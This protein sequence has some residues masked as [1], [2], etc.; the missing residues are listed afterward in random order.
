[1]VR[2]GLALDDA[3]AVAL[4]DTLTLGVTLGVAVRVPDGATVDD[5]DGVVGVAE[6]VAVG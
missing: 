4:G 2:V 5:A 3:D 6:T 1:V